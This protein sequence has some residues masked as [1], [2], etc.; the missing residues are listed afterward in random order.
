MYVQNSGWAVVLPKTH[1]PKGLQSPQLALLLIMLP[2][3][4]GFSFS[5]HTA[6]P[7]TRVGAL[8]HWK[9]VKRIRSFTEREGPREG[10]SPVLRTRTPH[11]ES[12]VSVPPQFRRGQTPL[13][14]RQCQPWLTPVSPRPK[15][16]E[17]NPRGSL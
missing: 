16:G 2:H 4:A 7:H 6:R 10:M 9:Q 12:V 3:P 17:S 1:L 5:H 14:G 11:L 8:I 15:N 13:Y